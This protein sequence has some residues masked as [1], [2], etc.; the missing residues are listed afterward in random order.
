MLYFVSKWGREKVICYSAKISPATRSMETKAQAKKK[1]TQKEKEEKNWKEYVFLHHYV[2][3]GLLYTFIVATTTMCNDDLT[4]LI[5]ENYFQWMAFK[6]YDI[7]AFT[8]YT[9][10]DL[11]MKHTIPFFCFILDETIR[12]HP[13]KSYSVL[14][15][16]AGK[17]NFWSP[18]PYRWCGK[19][20][21]IGFD[22]WNEKKIRFALRFLIFKCKDNTELFVLWSEIILKKKYKIII[23]K[24]WKHGISLGCETQPNVPQ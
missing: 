1:N 5:F 23:M 12:L 13:S 14:H 19:D 18:F 8:A 4:N 11:D 6:S 24:R 17:W 2:W 20:I 16:A 7:V 10:R 22:E 21:R 3:L 15:S 9:S